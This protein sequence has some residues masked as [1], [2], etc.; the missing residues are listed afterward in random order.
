MSSVLLGNNKKLTACVLM[1][2]ALIEDPTDDKSLKSVKN[3]P[4]F[5]ILGI[6]MVGTIDLPY[7]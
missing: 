1:Q 4:F 3:F 2:L 5:I 7:L 6:F